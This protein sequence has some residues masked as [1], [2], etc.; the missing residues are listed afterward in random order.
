MKICH[1]HRVITVLVVAWVAAA[2]AAAA[3]TPLVSV[4]PDSVVV[5]HE[6]LF[7]LDIEVSSGVTGLMGYDIAVTFDAD[8]IQLQSVSEGALPL[9][10]GYNTFFHWFNP[11]LSTDSVH[12]N[13]AILG[14]TVDGPGTLFT[15]EFKGY[16]PEGLRETDVHIAWS[17]LRDGVNVDITH[18]TADGWVQVQKSVRVEPVSWGYVKSR[19]GVGR[20]P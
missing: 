13:G 20:A 7:T 18:D 15:L 9:L 3:Q 6:Q 1:P 10:S 16:A 19:Y 14:N 12:V 4:V 17:V 2:T 11:S 8:V 5:P